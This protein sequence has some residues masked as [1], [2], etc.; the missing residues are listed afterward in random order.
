VADEEE[1]LAFGALAEKF[2]EVFEGGFGGEGGGVQDLGLVAGLGADER[3]GLETALKGAGD[4]QVELDVQRVEHMSELET[5]LLAFFVEW[6]FG[7]E[8][9]IFARLTGAGVAKY[10]QIHSLFTFYRRSVSGWWLC[11][12]SAVRCWS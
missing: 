5:V 8:E 4:D 3:C 10:I 6:A 9:R 7:V 12:E 11:D 2:L 1:V